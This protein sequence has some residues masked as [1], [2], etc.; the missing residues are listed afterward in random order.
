MTMET[1][2]KLSWFVGLIFTIFIMWK[3]GSLKKL[4]T[5]V[6]T[7]YEATKLHIV[8]LQREL[9][10]VHAD[11]NALIIEHDG[12][13]KELVKTVSQKKSSE[14][15]LG[16]ISEQMA[17]FTEQWPWESNDFRFIGSPIDGVQ[18]TED[19]LIFVEI[20][21]GKSR[22]SK[23]QVRVRELV[24]TGKVKFVSCRIDQNTIKFD[25]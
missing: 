15:R 5:D 12:V 9:S 14:V 19:C 4:Y 8:E 22:L 11:H 13:Q 17:P 1:I 3:Y 6:I 20:K 24:E 21:T 10:V 16:K 18:F 25:G 7:S 2:G 23:G